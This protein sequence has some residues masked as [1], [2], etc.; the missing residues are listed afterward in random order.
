M[1]VQL[2]DNTDPPHSN[3]LIQN[4]YQVSSLGMSQ[5]YAQGEVPVG[6]LHS[7]LNVAFALAVLA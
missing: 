2:S 6:N 3:L 1:C 7:K 4:I 5:G